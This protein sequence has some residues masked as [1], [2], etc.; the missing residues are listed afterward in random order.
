MEKDKFYFNDSYKFAHFDDI[1]G[2]ITD[3]NPDEATCKRLYSAG[4]T[5]L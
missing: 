1:D 2:I 4:V 3:S 5:I